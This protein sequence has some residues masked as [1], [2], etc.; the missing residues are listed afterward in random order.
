MKKLLL[1]LFS[2]MLSFNSYGEWV[3]IDKENNSDTEVYVLKESI[4]IEEG[5]VYWATLNNYSKP[6]SE[7]NLMGLAIFR[8]GDCENN[9]Y[10][11]IES[12]MFQ[13]SMGTKSFGERLK[14][15][16]EWTTPS[17]GQ[18]DEK[19]FNYVCD[20]AGL[21]RAEVQKGITLTFE[22][23]LANYIEKQKIKNAKREEINKEKTKIISLGEYLDKEKAGSPGTKLFDDKKVEWE[24]KHQ[25]TYCTYLTLNGKANTLSF[26][27]D[28]RDLDAKKKKERIQK[29]KEIVASLDTKLPER[30]QNSIIEMLSNQTVSMWDLGYLKLQMEIDKYLLNTDRS[31]RPMWSGI[32]VNKSAGLSFQLG[33]PPYGFLQGNEVTRGKDTEYVCDILRQHFSNKILGWNGDNDNKSTSYRALGGLFSPNST[34]KQKIT[35]GDLLLSDSTITFYDPNQPNKSVCSFNSLDEF[36][37]DFDNIIKLDKAS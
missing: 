19:I 30:L 22:E 29:V 12:Q 7:Y 10:V 27:M 32:N 20:Y 8:G 13:G 36:K 34:E 1:I 6:R 17:S 18:I 5:Y 21:G 14:P 16:Q 9:S 11:N 24:E 33:L 28:C 31:V 2:L 15:E 26:L 4:E 37:F 3:Y 35:I 25:E 23:E